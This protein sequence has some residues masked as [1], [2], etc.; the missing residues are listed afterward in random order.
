MS[1]PA[2][3]AALVLLLDA[4]ASIEDSDWNLQREATAEAFASDPV[5]R[6]VETAGVAVMT[7]AFA[8]FAEPSLGWQVLRTREDAA[9]YATALRGIE[10]PLERF[11]TAIGT[12][13]REATLALEEPPCEA[14]F[15]V[16]DVATDG[17]NT[18]G[19]RPAQMR[20][21]AYAA[22][23]RINGIGVGGEAGAELRENVVTNNGF[24]IETNNW[25]GFAAGMRR[26]LTWEIAGYGR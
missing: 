20:D 13:I 9:A 17:R 19:W 5:L 3:A 6:V 1:L 25:Q 12:A 16:I 8:E 26:K 18:T 24:V 10:R 22:D 14:D 7:M 21:L 23:I 4:S 2:C 15:K 11:G